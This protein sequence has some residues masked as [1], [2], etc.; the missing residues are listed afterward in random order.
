M[1]DIILL[2]LQYAGFA[3]PVDKDVIR[4]INELVQEDGVR[5]VAEVKRHLHSFVKKELEV[6]I[7]TTSNRFFPSDRDIRNH[8]YLAL[9]KS[10]YY[11]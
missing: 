7:S 2:I 3:Q 11:S 1:I 8:M 10:R 6:D 5:K 9:N 4:K